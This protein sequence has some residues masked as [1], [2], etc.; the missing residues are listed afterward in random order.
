MDPHLNIVK[1]P[2][3]KRYTANEK[4]RIKKVRDVGACPKCKKSKRK[5][6]HV[7]LDDNVGSGP[8]TRVGQSPST[9]VLD[10]A[11]DASHGSGTG[12]PPSTA[13]LD[14]P[15]DASHGTP[16]LLTAVEDFCEATPGGDYPDP[17]TPASQDS[18]FV[19]VTDSNHDYDAQAFTNPGQ[20]YPWGMSPSFTIG[21]AD[22]DLNPS[23][24]P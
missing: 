19:W 9:A 24:W 12:Q 5:C 14:V 13:V 22:H 2:V 10:V 23:Q 17:R 1:P 6:T 8:G 15:L 18:G 4:A 20:G 16:E 11:Q 21:P 7:A 3:K